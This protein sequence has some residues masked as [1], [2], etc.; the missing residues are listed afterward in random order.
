MGAGSD[1]RVWDSGLKGCDDKAGR[2]TVKRALR[3]RS[4]VLESVQ[5]VCLKGDLTVVCCWQAVSERQL[6]RPPWAPPY[7]SSAIGHPHKTYPARG[8]VPG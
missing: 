3:P 7:R 8:L 5:V 1:E 6:H 2:G 4:T